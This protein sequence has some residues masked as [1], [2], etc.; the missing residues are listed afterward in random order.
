MPIALLDNQRVHVTLWRLPP[1][2]STGRHRHELDFLVVP[3]TTGQLKL[4]EADGSNVQAELEA[5]VPSFQK[6]GDEHD[7]TNTNGFEFRFIEIEIK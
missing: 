6:A 2:T 5:G 3:L 7:V 4:A 1:G